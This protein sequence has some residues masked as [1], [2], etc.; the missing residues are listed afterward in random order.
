MTSSTRQASATDRAKIDT[1]S[2]ERQ[3]GT[4]P[5]ADIKPRDGLSP[6]IPL[7]AAGTRPDPAVSVPIA[8][9]TRPR[10]TATA[11]PDDEPPGTSDGS[12]AFRGIGKGVRRP[13]RP[14]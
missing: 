10:A 3:A 2:S 8:N 7:S 9:G 12:H 13:A 6:T 4:T 14:V 5:R 11:D 1:Q